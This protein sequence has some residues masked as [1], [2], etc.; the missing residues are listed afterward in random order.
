MINKT[1]GTEKAALLRWKAEESIKRKDGTAPIKDDMDLHQTIHEL[2]VHQIELEMQNEE[3]RRTQE[4]LDAARTRYFDLYDLAPVGYCIVSTEGLIL[5]ANLTVVTLL[6]LARSAL[7]RQPIT[8]FIHVE[9]QDIY[10]RHRKRLFDHCES[11]ACELRMVKKDGTS[12]W[13]RLTATA[14]QVPVEPSGHES[15][16]AP[17]SRLVV[18]DISERK[19]AE[20]EK[21]KLEL[22]LQ[23]IQKLETLG[24]LAGGVAHDFNNLLTTI[25]GNANLGSLAAEARTDTAPY[26][27]AIEKAAMKGADLNRQLLAYAGKGRCSESEMDLDIIVKEISELISVSVPETISFRYDLADRLP[28]VK[29]DPTQIFQILLNLILNASEAIPDRTEGLITICTRSE[30]IDAATL[31]LPGWALPLI[32]G[33]YVTL[34]VTDTGKGMDA[35]ILA[36]IFEPF[37][38][39]KFTGRGLGLAAVIGI[40]GSHRGGLRVHSTVGKGSSFKIFLPVLE[41]PRATLEGKAMPT[42]QGEG[43]ILVVD[44]A[45][46]TRRTARSLSERMGFSVIEAQSSAEAIELFRLH[47]G[48]LGLVLLN[49]VMPRM[50]GWKVLQEMRKINARVPVILSSG[51]RAG[52]DAHVEGLAGHLKKPYRVAEFQSALRRIF[53]AKEAPLNGEAPFNLETRPGLEPLRIEGTGPSQ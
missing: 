49:L 22:Q 26:F 46:P 39:T 52:D 28:F 48:D 21:A 10:Y 36:R 11:Y 20:A 3:L 45:E 31:G 42:W 47:H 33:P 1:S 5:E 53:A 41:G 30:T 29:G 15:A 2:R 24:T 34:E 18:S 37:F 35:E 12:F 44:D 17:V 8:R 38:S 13:A 43:R 19:A 27:A 32:P 50:D 25:V 16:W 40:L 9:D 4:Q 7:I 23:E 51:F 14:A 6:G